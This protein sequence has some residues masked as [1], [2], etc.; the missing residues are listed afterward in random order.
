MSQLLEIEYSELRY[1]G[2][3]VH[4]LFFV[5]VIEG[6]N[7]PIVQERSTWESCASVINYPGSWY[8]LIADFLK[9]QLA[10]GCADPYRSYYLVRVDEWDSAEYQIREAVDPR[11]AER[12]SW[13]SET[14][15]SQFRIRLPRR[16]QCSASDRKSPAPQ[17]ERKG[18][19]KMVRPDLNGGCHDRKSA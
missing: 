6:A 3:D 12:R 19:E 9:S 2:G 15:L 7:G 5:S 16:A 10:R 13:N 14:I 8:L 4:E 18:N 17:A 1:V 11:L